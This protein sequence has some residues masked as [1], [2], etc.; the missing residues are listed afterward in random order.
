[1]RQFHKDAGGEAVTE[2]DLGRYDEAATDNDV[3]RMDEAAVAQDQKKFVSQV[4]TRCNNY[5][6]ITVMSLNQ[7]AWNICLRGWHHA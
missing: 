6:P 4:Q 7:F 3:V 2:Y 5:L 1:M